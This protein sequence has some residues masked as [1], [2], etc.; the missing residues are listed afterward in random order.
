MQQVLIK[1]TTDLNEMVQ[2]IEPYL[3]PK[4]LI[5]LSGQ[6]GA[7]KTT[8]ISELLKNQNVAV[9]SPTFALYNSYSAFGSTIVHVDLY[10]LN[11]IEE[12]DSSGFWDL[13]ADSKSVILTEWVER[14]SLDE[15]PL[16]WNL[17]YLKIDFQP[18]HSRRY[19]LF[20]YRLGR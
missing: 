7:G 15:V 19:S 9:A 20:S 2:T 12:I 4:T 13:F 14:I 6:M 5:G 18:D 10:R 8:F 11:S 17:I 16:Q 3:K 1:Q